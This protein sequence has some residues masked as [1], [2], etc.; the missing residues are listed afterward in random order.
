LF[1]FLG[2]TRH[3]NRSGHGNVTGKTTQTTT[4]T[5]TDTHHTNHTSGSLALTYQQQS[6]YSQVQQQSKGTGTA[7]V[8]TTQSTQA[9]QYV[10]SEWKQGSYK[11]QGDSTTKSAQH[12][13]QQHPSQRWKTGHH[14]M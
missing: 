11:G 4:D 6:K 9:Q 12:Y 5:H 14:S 1:D 2:M 8:P 13:H 3:R 7:A 10:S